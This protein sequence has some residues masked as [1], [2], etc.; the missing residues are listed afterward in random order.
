MTTLELKDILI[1]KIT[2]INDK[3]FLS[4]IKT[5]IDAKS[6]TIVYKTTHEQRQSIKEGLMQIEKGG[7]LTNYQLETEI[8]QWLKKK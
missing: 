1:H 7:Y 3:P 5:I 8:D 2:V 4:A 6:E